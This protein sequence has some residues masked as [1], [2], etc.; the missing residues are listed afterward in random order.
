M[1]SKFEEWFQ[2]QPFYLNLRFIHGDQLFTSENGVYRVLAVQIAWA[3]WQE[4]QKWLDE[5]LQLIK[6]IKS[7]NDLWGCEQVAVQIELL[8][9]A[10]KGD[11]N[12]QHINR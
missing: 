11:M 1:K 4:Q 3:T 5:A 10:L 7:E 2:Q 8:E 6:S 12:E 9:Q